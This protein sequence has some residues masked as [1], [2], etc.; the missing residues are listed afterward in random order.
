MIRALRLFYDLIETQSFTATARRHYITQSA[1]SQQV[2]GLERQFGH[3]LLQKRGRQLTLTPPGRIVYEAA[4]EILW[5]YQ[6][7]E[8]ALAQTPK[9][10]EG[11]LRIAATLTVGLY[12]LPPHLSVF[13]ARH[14][15]VRLKLVYHAPKDVYRAVADQEVDL[16]FVEFP[17]PHAQ[18]SIVTMSRDQLV[19]VVPPSHPWAGQRRI[20]LTRLDEQPF[21]ALEAGSPSRRVLDQLFDSH[22]LRV[23]VVRE[24]DSLELIKRGIEAAS[25]VSILPRMAVANELRAETLRALDIAEGPFGYPIGIVT[26]KQMERSEPV[27]QL[28]TAM[29]SARPA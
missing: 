21:I 8:R 23:T 24:F 5:R 28:I 17:E 14:P 16:G 7:L 4:Q 1:V 27:Q 25:G 9:D 10:V 22:R 15:Q 29:L 19:I 26:R 12:E 6:R 18:L 13:L 2:K 3:R 11:P 20:S